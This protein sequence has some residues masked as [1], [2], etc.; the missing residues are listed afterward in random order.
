MDC[1][2]VGISVLASDSKLGKPARPGL[3]RHGAPVQACMPRI[4][5]A[6]VEIINESLPYV[7]KSPSNAGELCLYTISN[8][9]RSVPTEFD[10]EQFN[11]SEDFCSTSLTE[12][13]KVLFQRWRRWTIYRSSIRYLALPASCMSSSSQHRPLQDSYLHIVHWI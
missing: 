3:T 12:T 1:G 13:I 11:Y 9:E 5:G 2:I 8:P 6:G 10:V 7:Q 4:F